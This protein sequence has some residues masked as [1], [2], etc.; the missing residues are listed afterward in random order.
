[1]INLICDSALLS[2]YIFDTKKITEKIIDDVIKE[3]DFELPV[4]EF[5]QE[6]SLKQSIPEVKIFCCPKC[7]KYSSCEIKWERGIKGEE[8]ICCSKCQDYKH[9]QTNE[10]KSK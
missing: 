4:E 6:L 3:R 8:Q 2:G 1:M 5:I 9:C 7:K 10:I